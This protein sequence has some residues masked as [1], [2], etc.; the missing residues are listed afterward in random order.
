M[1][2]AAG[3]TCASRRA[4]CP[5][6]KQSPLA[7]SFQL[8]TQCNMDACAAHH[9]PAGRSS[10]ER[11]P[12]RQLLLETQAHVCRRTRG[13]HHGAVAMLRELRRKLARSLAIE[14]DR[15]Q[16]RT[17]PVQALEIVG[18]RLADGR[19]QA[20]FAFA[21]GQHVPQAEAVGEQARQ[22]FGVGQRIQVLA[23]QY[24]EQFP[25]L[26]DVLVNL[27]PAVELTHK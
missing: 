14:A 23:E 2:P 9:M 26:V 6:W 13:Q 8:I 24:A 22:T 5:M 4:C 25:E 19:I 11:A 1:A 10:E 15:L 20:A 12:V 21:G 17:Q 16:F 7:A 3:T 27:T 18:G